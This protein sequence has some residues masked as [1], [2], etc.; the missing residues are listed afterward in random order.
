MVGMAEALGAFS[1]EQDRRLPKE[2]REALCYHKEHLLFLRRAFQEEPVPVQERKLPKCQGWVCLDFTKVDWCQDKGLVDEEFCL[3]FPLGRTSIPNQSVEDK[4]VRFQ[5]VVDMLGRCSQASSTDTLSN[6]PKH[7]GPMQPKLQVAN[8]PLA[9]GAL[10]VGELDSL[11]D[12]V[13]LGQSL[14]ILLELE[15][16]LEESH[17]ARLR[18]PNTV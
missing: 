2:V 14:D 18:L 12:K 15:W 4:E 5:E 10:V 1:Q 7:K 11:E 9:T 16:G 6:H 17:L 8:F 13:A 3:E